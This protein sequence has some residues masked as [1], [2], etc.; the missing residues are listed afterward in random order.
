MSRRIRTIHMSL[1]HCDTVVSAW[2]RVVYLIFKYHW[3]YTPCILSKLEYDNLLNDSTVIAAQVSK[4]CG[5][6][7][8]QKIAS[9]FVLTRTKN[10]LVH[11]LGLQALIL[12]LA[13]PI[14]T[15]IYTT[16]NQSAELGY[17]HIASGHSL[18]YYYGINI[19]FELNTWNPVKRQHTCQTVILWVLEQRQC[20]HRKVI[21]AAMFF[22]E[23][24]SKASRIGGEQKYTQ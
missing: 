14:V 19:L 18:Y 6:S 11:G 8:I 10:Y 16:Q 1:N 3:T 22:I 5:T 2:F 15:N 21:T 23:I 24:I 4:N 17:H 12:W 20:N 9:N 7:Y 13:F